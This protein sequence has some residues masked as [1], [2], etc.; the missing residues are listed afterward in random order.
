MSLTTKVVVDEVEVL[1]S[2]MKRWNISTK[3]KADEEK[4]KKPA[5]DLSQ[6]LT[7]LLSLSSIGTFVLNSA[8]IVEKKLLKVTPAEFMRHA[9]HWLILLGR[10]ICKARKPDCPLCPVADLCRFKGKTIA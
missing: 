1:L 6:K 3:G 5:L 9:H 10:Y 4:L 7:S 8:L 2:L